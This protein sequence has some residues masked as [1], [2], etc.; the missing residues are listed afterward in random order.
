LIFSDDSDLFDI[1]PTTGRISFTPSKEDIGSHTATITVTDQD[2][3]SDSETFSFSIKEASEE[4]GFDFRWIIII[5]VVGVVA[6]LIGFMLNRGPKEKA[7]QPI[8]PLQPQTQPIAPI[9]PQN[10]NRYQYK[11]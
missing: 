1:N 6:F 7:P 2:G 9:Q 10:Y 3:N 11:Q 8:A 5:I 4:E